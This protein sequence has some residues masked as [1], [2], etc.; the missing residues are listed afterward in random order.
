MLNHQE[1]IVVP[2]CSKGSSIFYGNHR[3]FQIGSEIKAH[4][5]QVPFGVKFDGIKVCE[6]ESF[7]LKWNN[8][9]IA[10]NNQK[11]ISQLSNELVK[12]FL[13][14]CNRDEFNPIRSNQRPY[15]KSIR[16]SVH[17]MVFHN[18]KFH[19]TGIKLV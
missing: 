6:L 12:A 4:T 14:D 9:K 19:V 16:C 8:E 15:A 3:E 13:P 11:I 5:A 10:K 2:V 7:P 1:F 17:R 18:G